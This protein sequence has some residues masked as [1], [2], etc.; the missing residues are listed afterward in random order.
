MYLPN[1]FSPSSLAKLGVAI[2]SSK[3]GVKGEH[4]P[5]LQQQFKANFKFASTSKLRSLAVEVLV[6][7][8]RTYKTPWRRDGGAAAAK[9]FISLKR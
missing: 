7:R 6:A 8:M 9:L 3:I 1:L 4:S 2:L 5:D